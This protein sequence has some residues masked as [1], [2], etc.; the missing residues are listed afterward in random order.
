MKKQ[1]P[2]SPHI[3]IYS[4]EFTSV[5]S[6][7]HRLSGVFNVLGLVIISFYIL[8]LAFWGNCP[9]KTCDCALFTSAINIF[10]L[11]FIWSIYHHL[12]GGIRHLLLDIGVGFN[13]KKARI[14]AYGVFI[15]SFIATFITWLIYYNVI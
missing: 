3:Q 15:L 4:A 6:I 10:M 1:R 11:L 8:K 5:S 14:I 7:F 13:I 12:F 9:M 2:T